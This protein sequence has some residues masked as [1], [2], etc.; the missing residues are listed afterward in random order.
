MASVKETMRY[1]LLNYPTLYGSCPIKAL[2]QWFAVN[3]NG[4]EWSR[5]GELVDMCEPRRKHTPLAMDYS[6]LDEDEARLKADFGDSLDSPSYIALHTARKLRVSAARIQRKWVEDNIELILDGDLTE[7]YFTESFSVKRTTYVT[8]PHICLQYARACAFPDNITNE[9]GELLLKYLDNWLQTLNAHYMVG[10]KKGEETAHW[11][12]EIVEAYE[13]LKA[14]KV[15]LWPLVRGE[16][17]AVY[18]ARSKALIT[19]FLASINEK[20]EKRERL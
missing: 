1:S 13:T 19:E 11:P 9:W 4:M 7:H 12:K 14:T 3:G 15:R 5:N 18:Q 10:N 8:G 17:Y 2:D 20:R 6:D 16:D